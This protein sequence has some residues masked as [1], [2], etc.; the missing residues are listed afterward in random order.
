MAAQERLPTVRL[1]PGMVIERSVRIVSGTY[2]LPAPESLDSAVVA[3][4]GDGITVDFAGAT[5]EGA[6][7]EAD[8]DRAR[9]VAIR[10][11]G[12]RNVRIVNAKVRG[13]RIGILARGT[14]GFHLSDSDLSYNWKPRLYSLVEHESLLDWLSFHD[15][16]DDEWLRFGAAIYLDGVTGGEISGTT[17]VQGMN[18]LLMN[19]TDSLTVRDNDF[20]FNSGLGIGMYR[21]DD[22]RIVRNRV[23]F[24]VRGYS[25]GFYHRGQDSAGILLYEGC[26][27]NLVAY[28]SATHGGDGLFIWAGRSTL[29][30]GRG[31]VNDNLIWGNDFSFA[32]ANSME[33]TFSRNT[34]VAN[35]AEGSD[36]GVWGGYSYESAFVGNCFLRNRIGIAI[37]HGQEN[38]IG[39]NLFL[40][41]TTAVS[42]WANRS[43]PEE[44]GYPRHRD[45]RSRDTRVEGNLFIGNRVGVRGVRTSG[46]AVVGNRLV[47]VD[48][49]RA[50]GDGSSIE[51]GASNEIL[52]PSE[53]GGEPE[54]T[55]ARA[56][57][58]A[59]EAAAPADC[60]AVPS[61][62]PQYAALAPRL[63]GGTEVPSSPLARR[64]RSAIVVDEWG[65]Y[66][67]R[68]PKLWPIDSV[69][70][71][72]LRLAVL[73]PPGS[74]RLVG[75]TGIAAV[76]DSAGRTVDTISVTPRGGVVDW[77]ITL[78][79][80]GSETVT[81]R[82]LRRR[83]G[84]PVRF[85][86]GRFEPAVA[87][88][89]RFF[90]W[91]GTGPE[92][93]SPA[94][95]DFEQVTAT[96]PI[97]TARPPR[98]DYQWYRPRVEELPLER[99]ALEATGEVVLPPGEYTLRT[100]SD[101]GIRVW[102]D[103]ELVIDNWTPHGS[104][105]D[106]APLAPGRHELRV[107]YYQV[108]GWTELRV[109]IVRGSARSPGSPRPH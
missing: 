1:R 43:E 85:A 73:G 63:E 66:D 98:L 75:R 106:F 26:T 9:G 91:G 17:V 20:S 40:G 8:P 3:I 11:D 39:S 55:G 100:I 81:P 89:A 95:P 105:L 102:V 6:D 13:Y 41:D 64:D 54:R 42:V 23:D 104:E 28:N 90:A 4:R 70:A 68:S 59:V 101:D 77:E 19:R 103:G 50:I 29:E 82:G 37:E 87:W 94:P 56:A 31:G 51:W 84:V 24:D 7:P 86:Y 92:P 27:G 80:R 57:V 36:Y 18:A 108:G 93:E 71:V 97:L 58:G 21:S 76:S 109:E 44:W 74:W 34:F 16:E 88:N 72:P 2:R 32:P 99:W 60:D 15:N 47:G 67:W 107:E 65:P 49:A 35:R 62:P 45:T 22:N 25:H 78:E 79:Y 96:E 46:L 10:V 48:S 12:G 53:E 52:D 61:L 33:A 38:L 5:L 69:W 83:A 14:R 30:T